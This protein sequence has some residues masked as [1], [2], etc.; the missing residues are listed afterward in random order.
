MKIDWETWEKERERRQKI[1][2]AMNDRIR[3]DGVETIGLEAKDWIILR[4]LFV[5][6]KEGRN[7]NEE[8]ARKTID[9]FLSSHPG[10]G[11][12]IMYAAF[13]KLAGE[14]RTRDSKLYEPYWRGEGKWE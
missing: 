9:W 13:S 7:A 3:H 11:Q 2:N 4:L 6:F 14:N 10:Y 12:E 5:L 1:A 8:E